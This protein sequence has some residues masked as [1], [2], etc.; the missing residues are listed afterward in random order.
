M[1]NSWWLTQMMPIVAKLTTYAAY[2]GHCVSNAAPRSWP[3]SGTCNSS[4]S[5]VAAIASTPS[6]KASSRADVTPS[7]EAVT[8]LDH[9]ECFWHGDASGQC[10]RKASSSH[11][12]TTV[13]TTFASS[14]NP[15]TPLVPSQSETTD[16]SDTRLTVAPRRP[17]AR[18]SAAK[19][20]SGKRTRSSAWPCG[21]KWWT[22]APYAE[23]L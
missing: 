9:A 15:G 18:P 3:A 16:R 20:T 6:L 10:P 1:N 22:S 14:T 8:S 4:T 5:S 21:P 7:A 17:T 11:S 19:S 23:S 12:A 2:E 13:G